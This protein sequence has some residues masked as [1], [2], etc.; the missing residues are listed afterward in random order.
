MWKRSSTGVNL[1]F[2]FSLTSCLTT[3]KG[4]NLPDYLS[5]AEEE[6]LDSYLTKSISGTEKCK[7]FYPRVE[8]G[9]R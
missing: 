9:S 1:E 3:V 4:P 8:L 5:I 2:S 7:Q 6:L